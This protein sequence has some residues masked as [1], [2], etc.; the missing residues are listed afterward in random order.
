MPA[1]RTI[2]PGRVA[3]GLL[4]LAALLALGVV[5]FFFD[6]SRHNFYPACMFHKLTGWNCPGCGG[7]RAL[8]HLAHG[9]VVTAFHCNPL[10]IAL[11]PFLLLIGVRWLTNGG[12]AFNGNTVFFRPV[13]LWTLLAI[14]LLFTVLR[15]LPGPAFAWMSP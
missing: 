12:Q 8:H 15:N 14:T 7:L 5:F 1:T 13:V 6:P 11:L 10:F 4:A 2:P 9:N 3:L